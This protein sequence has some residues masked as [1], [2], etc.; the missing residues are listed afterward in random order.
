MLNIIVCIGSHNSLQPKEAEVDSF[1]RM[2]LQKVVK[3]INMP[4]KYFMECIENESKALETDEFDGDDDDEED[5]DFEEDDSSYYDETVTRQESIQFLTEVKEMIGDH[6]NCNTNTSGYV[7]ESLATTSSIV[8][9]DSITIT[10]T[11]TLF[12]SDSDGSLDR[13]STYDKSQSFEGE[14]SLDEYVWEVECTKEF[15]KSFTKLDQPSKHQALKKIDR[16]AKGEWR[17]FIPAKVKKGHD[18]HLFYINVTTNLRIIWQ[19][20]IAYS[21][22]KTIKCRNEKVCDKTDVVYSQIIRIWKIAAVK[23]MKK[24]IKLIQEA[25]CKDKFCNPDVGFKTLRILTSGRNNVQKSTPTLYYPIKSDSVSDECVPV[26]YP[27]NHKNTPLQLYKMDTALFY[28]SYSE[29][30]VSVNNYQ[31]FLLEQKLSPEENNIIDMDP[32]E[33]IVLLGRSGTGKTICC[34]H[35]LWKQFYDYWRTKDKEEIATAQDHLRQVFITKSSILCSRVKKR[36]CNFMLGRKDVWQQFLNQQF[37][38]N[39]LIKHIKVQKFHPCAFPCF[40]TFRSWLLLLDLSLEGKSFFKYNK[41]GSL[42]TNII[43]SECVDG[44]FEDIE[45]FDVDLSQQFPTC[46]QNKRSWRKVDSDF[47]IS[48]IWPKLKCRKAMKVDPILV[49]MEIHSFIKGSL[50]ALKTINGQLTK[51][52]YIDFGAKMAPNF[53]DSR[54]F[55]YSCY[56]EY[57]HIKQ[58]NGYFDDN[59]LIHNLFHRLI[60]MKNK[61]PLIHQLYV[62]EVQ[63]FTQ[64]ELALLLQCSHVPSGQ[65]LTGDTAQNIMRSVS[66]R[67][68]DLQ[69]LFHDFQKNLDENIKV[70]KINTLMHNFRSHSGI[71]KLAASIIDL[72]MN[73]F[74]SSLDELPADQGMFPGPKPILI[75][76]CS[77]SDLAQIVTVNRE[78]S[79]AIE[80]GARQAIIVRSEQAKTM[81]PDELKVGIVLTVN[82]AKGL[83]FDDVLLY[84]FFADSEVC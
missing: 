49:W 1:E 9:L 70:P 25:V 32:Q 60:K 52:K 21:P 82:E 34:L 29:S 45:L 11:E 58:R 33:S 48:K 68:C 57:E 50:E 47:F 59:D 67:F 10:D 40:L 72:L 62:D 54:Y 8:L 53:K 22:R 69:S 73:F 15:W 18:L 16:L 75:S 43:E 20:A 28:N 17:N 41:D 61:E 80:F 71:L 81:L 42:S 44:N 51:E 65:F 24:S 64:A 19:L 23:S 26:Y 46:T 74:K 2:V 30:S 66:F 36:F 27:A 3:L 77:H 31:G 5:H 39:E 63:D 76:S 37:Q 6:D 14:L 4:S 55:I 79:G 35:R 83:E 56:E 38:N 13:M 84:N 7:S 78:E 12:G